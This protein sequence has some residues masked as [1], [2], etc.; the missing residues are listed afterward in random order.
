MN[1]SFFKPR[2]LL[3]ATALAAGAASAQSTDTSAPNTAMNSN[4]SVGASTSSTPPINS[5]PAAGNSGMLDSSTSATAP[6]SDATI[7]AA[8]ADTPK[9]IGTTSSN[10]STQVSAS[11]SATHQSPL[12]SAASKTAGARSK[13]VAKANPVDTQYRAELRNC[14]QMTGAERDSCLDRAIQNHPQG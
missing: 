7:L 4:T 3:L 13:T 5:K 12:R 2:I 11:A 14:V 1:P 8:A 10:D 6:S 9:Q